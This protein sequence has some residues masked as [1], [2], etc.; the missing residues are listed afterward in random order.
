MRESLNLLNNHQREVCCF[1][2]RSI[3]DT[4]IKYYKVQK[5]VCMG[6][7]FTIQN[8]WAE[9]PFHVDFIAPLDPCM[10][11]Q[12]S[13]DMFKGV[14]THIGQRKPARRKCGRCFLA[15]RLVLL[16]V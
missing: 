10:S 8:K 11:F 6:E 3:Y 14:K 4:L 7:S 13:G 16:R 9:R 1:T 2:R 5:N 12:L 15:A